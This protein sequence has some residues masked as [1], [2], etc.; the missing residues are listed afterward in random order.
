MIEGVK[1]RARQFAVCAVEE[2]GSFLEA[3]KEEFEVGKD[4]VFH[5]LIFSG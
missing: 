3:S 4:G 5:G 1:A 2:S